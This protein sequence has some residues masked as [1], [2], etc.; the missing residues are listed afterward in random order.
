MLFGALVLSLFQPPEVVLR[1]NLHP[2]DVVAMRE[3]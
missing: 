3:R 2:V 1:Y